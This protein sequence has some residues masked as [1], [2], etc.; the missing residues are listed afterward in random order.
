M[1][2]VYPSLTLPA[3][4]HFGPAFDLHDLT[5]EDFFRQNVE[6]P[7]APSALLDFLRKRVEGEAFL[8]RVRDEEIEAAE[9]EVAWHVHHKSLVQS[10]EA[11][12]L[13]DKVIFLQPPKGSV[14]LFL[15]SAEE[16]DAGERLYKWI[17]YRSG[18]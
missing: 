13:A 16:A 3:V 17:V 12:G 15:Q 2:S 7:K 11:A 10:L 4:L 6:D 18:W 5:A 8:Q 14:L 9:D 1:A